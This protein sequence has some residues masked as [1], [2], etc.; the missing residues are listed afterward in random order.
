MRDVW[1]AL[2]R[3]ERAA[4]F[5]CVGA[6]LAVAASC[7]GTLL[8]PKLAVGGRWSPSAGGD[9]SAAAPEDWR[10]LFCPP[11]RTPWS[12][13]YLELAWLRAALLVN[14]SSTGAEGQPAH[15]EGQPTA[16]QL[17]QPG[18]AQPA[19]NAS[20]QLTPVQL[21][22]VQRYA[23][24]SPGSMPWRDA[25]AVYVRLYTSGND[26]FKG[27]L[28]CVVWCVRRLETDA[29]CS[30]HPGVQQRQHASDSG[31]GRG[32]DAALAGSLFADVH[33]RA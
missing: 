33:V 10:L 30:E 3:C 20:A 2:R 26:V 28:T 25:G 11:V 13:D 9:Q 5:V 16:R 15:A 8:R 12:F 17:L 6:L 22:A 4:A 14:A 31:C 1:H 23:R 32:G 24:W 7:T 18:A 27:E 29:P 19:V 21:A